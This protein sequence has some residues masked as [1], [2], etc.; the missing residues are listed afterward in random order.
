M[1]LDLNI[2][3]SIGMRVGRKLAVAAS[4][5]L[6]P[7]LLLAA[8]QWAAHSGRFPPNLLIPP[9]QVWQAFIAILQDGELAVHLQYSLSRLALGFVF[10]ALPGMAFGCALALSRQVEI[11][12]GL[13]FHALR[14]IPS[15]ALIPM[16]VLLFGIEEHFKIAIVALALFFPVALATCEAVRDIPRRHFEVARVYRLSLPT[17]LAEVALPAAAPGIVTGLRIGL[18]RAWVVLVASELLAADSGLG[19]LIEMSR[20]MMRIDLVMVGMVLIGVIGFAIDGLFRLL[21]RRLSR[22]KVA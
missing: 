21:E 9:L 6:S 8:W 7:L 11:Y 12:C 19:Q 15:L 14:Q 5:L 16:F 22:W 17:V 1:S 3:I 10:G 13:L 20:Q 18:T 2:G 4:W